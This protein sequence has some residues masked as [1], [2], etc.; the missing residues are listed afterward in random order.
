MHDPNVVYYMY[1][2]IFDLATCPE[3]VCTENTGNVLMYNTKLRCG[4]GIPKVVH[5]QTGGQLLQ[6][7]IEGI[8]TATNKQGPN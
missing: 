7:Q 6:G 5:K 4:C 1:M 2:H 3:C 8:T